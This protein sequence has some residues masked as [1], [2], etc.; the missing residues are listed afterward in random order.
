M[1]KYESKKEESESLLSKIVTT[2]RNTF[3][4]GALA[5]AIGL[6]GGCGGEVTR[7]DPY[8]PNP[9]PT[10]TPTP[11]PTPTVTPTPTP[12]PGTLTLEQAVDLRV[13]KDQIYL[14]GGHLSS[15][16]LK[17]ESYFLLD[18]WN[19]P[20]NSG[21]SYTRF[22][23]RILATGTKENG[24]PFLDHNGDVFTEETWFDQMRF[25]INL[26]L[27]DGEI[28]DT[29]SGGYGIEINDTT[30][31]VKVFQKYQ[32]AGQ[33]TESYTTGIVK[34]SDFEM[35]NLKVLT[36]SMLKKV[37]A[38][39]ESVWGAGNYDTSTGEQVPQEV[40]EQQLY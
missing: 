22:F 11:T 9:T 36:H 6:S 25:W 20:D 32:S 37:Y 26:Y 5:V 12:T 35:F 34:I 18:E 10:Y 33:P 28:D 8:V 14:T 27:P 17:S 16:V 19:Y 21:T 30:N 3:L 15:H 13:N 4:T 29:L 24:D 2:A 40:F 39:N 23:A 31:L 38:A 1:E 7:T